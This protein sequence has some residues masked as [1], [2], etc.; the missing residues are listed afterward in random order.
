MIAVIKN[1]KEVIETR[2]IDKMNKEL[3]EFL[4]LHCGFIAHYDINGFKAT[5]RSPRDFAEVFIRHFDRQHRYYSGIYRCHEE[6]YK[7]TGLTKAQIKIEF[8]RIVTVTKKKS[9]VGQKR[10][11]EKNVTPSTSNSKRNSKEV[12]PMSIGFSTYDHWVPLHDLK[13]LE[14]EERGNQWLDDY[15]PELENLEAIW[16]VLNPTQAPQYLTL[17]IGSET[18]EYLFRIDLTG[19]TPVLEDEDGRIL[20]IRKKG[21]EKDEFRI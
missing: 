11:K 4:N 20:Y 10:N 14:I 3:Y 16:V 2:N 19:A 17:T 12:K 5:Y 8:E 7:D 6:A 18:E 13:E 9:P 15:E 1:F 21:G